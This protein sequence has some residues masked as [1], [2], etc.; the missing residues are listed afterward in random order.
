MDNTSKVF[1]CLAVFLISLK[2]LLVAGDVLAD[3]GLE[4]QA[5]AGYGRGMSE[6]FD[7]LDG[8]RY[9]S[10]GLMYDRRYWVSAGYERGQDKFYGQPMAEVRAYTAMAGIR[11]PV[12]ENLNFV[13]GAGMWWPSL[14]IRGEIQDE[15]T[16]T[17]LVN[18][19]HN[20]GRPIP[21]IPS[22]PDA[23]GMRQKYRGCLTE[24]VDNCY[25]STYQLEP[26]PLIVLGLEYDINSYTTVGIRYRW[27]RASTYMAIGINDGRIHMDW[28]EAPGGWWME[29]GT[30][31]FDTLSLELKLNF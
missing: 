11:V 29:D 13:G 26:S 16:Y 23:T 7:G 4:I 2:V 3:E 31:N 15:M 22:Y 5:G 28:D 8:L 17:H 18:R 30:R 24:Q 20:E 25:D 6:S 10:L 12:A 14:S 1:W 9:G 19:H 27:L 21:L